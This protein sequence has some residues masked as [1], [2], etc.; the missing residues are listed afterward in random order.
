[1][2]P[3]DLTDTVPLSAQFRATLATQR[4]H[5]L[6]DLAGQCYAMIAFRTYAVWDVLTTAYLGAPQLFTLRD[7]TIRVETHGASMGRTLRDPAGRRVQV[8]ADVQH[9]AFWDEIA[10]RWAR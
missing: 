1:M 7:E 8:L 3:L 2:C 5:A 9:Q 6:S 10:R 4:H